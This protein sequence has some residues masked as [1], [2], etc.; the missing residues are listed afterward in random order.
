MSASNRQVIPLR[1][2]MATPAAR[3]C[4]VALFLTLSGHVPAQAPST[5]VDTRQ[6]NTASQ[7]A[8]EM[9]EV[10]VTG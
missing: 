10:I 6:D 7:F 5:P 1:V 2:V 8:G 4:L 9:E 3:P